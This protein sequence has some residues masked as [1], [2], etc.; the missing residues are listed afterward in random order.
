MSL[1]F[2]TYA[3]YPAAVPACNPGMDQR[4]RDMQFKVL[5]QA[6]SAFVLALA[7]ANPAA[8][9]TIDFEG[10]G[11]QIDVNGYY[12]GGTASDGR[13][14][15]NLGVAFQGFTTFFG[16]N[17]GTIGYNSND[18][19]FADVAAGFSSLS[20]QYGFFT[21]GTVSVYS[22][23]GGTGTLL[24]SQVFLANTE[25]TSQPF[26]LGSV[27][28]SGIGRSLVLSG[29]DGSLGLDNIDFGTSTVGAVPEPATWAM[30]LLGFGV[31]GASLRRR[32]YTATVRYT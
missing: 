15:P 14:G 1:P 21:S 28:F 24:G 31:V 20:F 6:S 16:A 27:S 30:M 26:G 5:L 18:P 11:D 25:D 23:L 22:G 10:I 19:A 13:S 8:A 7:F 3:Y 32:K 9:V 2:R 29:T 12:S 17:G 4:G